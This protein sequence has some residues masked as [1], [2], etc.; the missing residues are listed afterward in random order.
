ML[1]QTPYQPKTW[2]GRWLEKRLPVI[3]LVVDQFVSFP[4]P[5]TLNYWW[6]FGMVLSVMLIIQLITGI[7]LAMHYTPHASMA[8]DSI[9]HI[10]R[11]VQ[12]GWLIRYM[13]ANGASFF[14]L[15]LFIHMFRCL[16]YGS[17]KAPREV[18]WWFGVLILLTMM[19]TGFT[20]YVL[21]WGQMS[22]W[23]ATVITNLFSAIPEYGDEIVI[24]LLG[25]YSVDNPT[26][27]RFYSLH[28]LLP[29]IIAALVAIHVWALHVVGSN[30]PTGIE[31]KSLDETVPFT[32]YATM[33][34]IFVVA[35]F[36]LLF[37]WFLF[38]QPNYLGHPD[39][40]IPADPLKTPPHIVPEWYFLPFYAILRAV[41][42]K[43]G[44]VVAMFASIL[45]LFLLPWLDWS[46]VRSG[47]FRPLF[48]LFFW[49]LV[50]DCILLGW[51]GAKPAE[52]I[53]VEIAQFATIYYFAHF[54]L[55]LPLLGLFD[56]PKRLPE[57]I[58]AAVATLDE[59]KAAAAEQAALERVMRA[60]DAEDR[61]KAGDTATAEE[62]AKAD[63]AAKP[64]PAAEAPAAGEPPGAE[65][66]AATED[67]S[68]VQREKA[69]GER[70]SAAGA[71]DKKD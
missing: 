62:T 22:Y 41:P 10:M 60:Q 70:G 24:W 28:Y 63:D 68:D 7:V 3:S 53:Y 57:S 42:D 15:A 26:L 66:A 20:G 54:L 46:R 64:E 27:V 40:Y 47:T 37:A 49:I 18:L 56:R 16:Y 13:H 35:V 14:F 8:F 1:G 6:T 59:K 32:P 21:P 44:G 39:N 29:M 51:L 30:N 58:T 65:P 2:I 43:L 9:E 50:A 45:V 71:P 4:T 5:K 33:K 25:G 17:Y 31:P 34:D 23:A 11:D 55:V 61:A 19:T 36:L 12:Y 38:F 52:G 69:A 67:A 48:R